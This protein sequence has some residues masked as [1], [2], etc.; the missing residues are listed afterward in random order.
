[1]SFISTFTSLSKRGWGSV[2]TFVWVWIQEFL[3]ANIWT[4]A[5]GTGFG[6]K[7]AVGENPNYLAISQSDW[8]LYPLPSPIKTD[9][10]SLYLQTSGNYNFVTYLNPPVT[11][12]GT[13]TASN[14]TFNT[15]TVS[16]TAGFYKNQGITF[17]GTLFGGVQ[18]SSQYFIKDIV[19]STEFTIG[20]Q[21]SSFP[22]IPLTNGSGSMGM[23]TSFYGWGI[24]GLHI[25]ENSTVI[26]FVADSSM[27]MYT[28]SGSTWTMTQQITDLSASDPTY[29]VYKVSRGLLDRSGDYML[30]TSGPAGGSGTA[31]IYFRSGSTWSLQQSIDITALGYSNIQGID[32]SGNG[33]YISIITV[34][35]G[36]GVFN[37]LVY[38]RSG[39]SWTLQQTINFGTSLAIGFITISI[40]GA[41]DTLAISKYVNPIEVFI[42]TRSG[43]TWSLQQTIPQPTSPLAFGFSR[44]MW[45]NDPGDV[46]F[47]GA[48]NGGAPKNQFYSTG[49]VLI[50]KLVNSTFTYSTYVTLPNDQYSRNSNFSYPT[51]AASTSGNI[52]GV[53]SSGGTNVPFQ[54][55]GQVD[56]FDRLNV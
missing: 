47:I 46:L 36:S 30:L 50:Y 25:N 17:T 42:Y 37:L 18:S 53:A 29:G 2:S 20:E 11:V 19:S 24:N 38:N 15:M 56:V 31:F 33:E 44:T 48:P 26:S 28:R 52:L 27:F 45:L 43:S 16:S 5:N 8:Y 3:P 7:I 41:G 49:I 21:E 34:N 9:S 54:E 1:M 23:E 10:I 39:T 12:L 4:P 6:H 13:V 14:S 35:A 55:I 40:N 22:S 32:M 51:I